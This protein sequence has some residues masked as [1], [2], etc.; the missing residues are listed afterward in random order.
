MIRALRR[1]MLVAVALLAAG[2]AC[3]LVLTDV[4]RRIELTTVDAR[5]GL[6]GER[7]FGDLVVVGI[8]DVTFDTFDERWPFSRNRFADV[9]ENV[10]ADQPKVIAYDVQFTEQ[11][12]DARADNRLIEASRAAGNVVFSTTE[13]GDHG[14][15][16]VF[17]GAEQLEYARATAGNGLLPEDTGGVLRRVPQQIDGL[18]TLAVA[19]V[20]RLGEQ[21]PAEQL[22]GKGAW[23]DYIGPPGHV[24]HVHFSDVAAGDVT[25]GRF[26]DRIVVIGA[27]A[28]S[29][30]DLHPVSWPSGEM[31]GPE[32]HANAIATLLAGAPLR[33]SGRG[34]DLALALGLALLTPLL[35]LFVRPWAGLLVTVA[36][37][38]TYAVA[39]QLLFNAGWIVPSSRRSRGW[40]SASSARCSSTG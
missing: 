25:P 15:S 18:D 39:A 11:S 16:N 14:E 24:P 6:R 40:R 7:S 30:Q 35:G 31:D 33:A 13:V 17:G 37:G 27:T 29:L 38:L 19:T 9:L 8:D 10:S 34:V 21:N 2:V 3:L 22:G 20:R 12:D 23:I 36:A 28:P 4:A 32:I 26:R 1:R 5:F